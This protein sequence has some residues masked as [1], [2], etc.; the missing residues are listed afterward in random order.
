MHITVTDS[1]PYL[2]Y[3]APPLAQQFIV[4]NQ[5]GESV[6]YQ[7]GREFATDQKVTALCRCGRSKGAPYCDSSHLTAAWNPQLTASMSSLLSEAEMLEG[8]SITLV[9][10]EQLCVYAR[11]CHPQGGTWRLTEHSED[12]NARREAIRQASLC[13]GSRL[14]AWGRDEEKPFELE[15]KPDLGLLEDPAIGVSSGIWVRGG[16]PIYNED[17]ESYEVRNRVVLCRCGSSHNKPFCD[18]AHAQMRWSDNINLSFG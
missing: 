13:P 3:G 1:G 17:G 7:K 16:I 4:V 10:D 2:V 18:G 9:D 5:K 15:Y 6:E 12:Q 11:F 8:E 14:T